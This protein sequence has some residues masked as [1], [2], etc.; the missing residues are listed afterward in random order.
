MKAEKNKIQ[1]IENFKPH[2]PVAV[3]SGDQPQRI[4]SRKVSQ[5]IKQELSSKEKGFLSDFLKADAKGSGSAKKIDDSILERQKYEKLADTTLRYC[6][7]D[8]IMKFISSGVSAYM[9]K[10][11][12]QIKCQNLG[13]KVE[14]YFEYVKD[15]LR[16]ILRQ[17]VPGL[18]SPKPRG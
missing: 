14:Q 1:A 3:I 13:G 15:E 18:D 16:F 12:L 10:D 7:S 4:P 8:E 5:V 2:E 11:I 6:T 17:I 9:A